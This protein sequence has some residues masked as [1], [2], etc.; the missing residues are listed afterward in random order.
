M[1]FLGGQP[2]QVLTTFV[3]LSLTHSHETCLSFTL[4]SP[5]RCA[6]CIVCHW[7]K[8]AADAATWQLPQILYSVYSELPSVITASAPDN[9]EDAACILLTTIGHLHHLCMFAWVLRNDLT[10]DGIVLSHNRVR[11]NSIQHVY[12]GLPTRDGLL[13]WDQRETGTLCN[14]YTTSS[15]LSF[16]DS[17]DCHNLPKQRSWD[18]SC[19][20]PQR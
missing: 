2:G 19:R 12:V 8:L 16:P 7:N 20:D 11:V 14:S 6:I 18:E 13:V 1:V 9:S 4:S 15:G 5:A 17:I 10:D 3:G